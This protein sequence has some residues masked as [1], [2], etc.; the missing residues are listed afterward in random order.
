MLEVRQLSLFQTTH[1]VVEEL[2]D[3]DILSMSPL[4]AINKL[5]ELKKKAQ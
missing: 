5:F 4:E 3:M 2:R 1:P